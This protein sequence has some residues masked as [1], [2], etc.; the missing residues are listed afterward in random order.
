VTYVY[1]SLDR[2]V[3]ETDPPITDRVT[4][5]V[6]TEVTTYTY[7]PD[8]DVLTTSISDATGG[9][10]SRATTTTY[11]AYGDLASVTDPLGNVSKYTY[12]ALGDRIT[13]TNPAGVTTAY[14]YDAAGNLLTTS[15]EGYTGNPSNP[16]TAENLVQDSRSYDPAGNLASDTSVKGTTTHYTYYGNGQLASSYVVGSAGDEDVHTYTY[17]AAGNKVSETDPG[18]LVVNT[19]YNADSQVT[20]QTTDPAGVDHTTSAVYDADGNVVTQ[21]LTGGGV[22]QTETTTYNAMD[23]VLPQTTDKTG[24]NATTTYTRDHRGL[25]VSETD[26]AG[27]T[28]TYENDEAGR[29]VVT[30][31]PAVA[32][33]TGNGAAP[34]TA[35]PVTMIGYDTFGDE[36]ETSDADGNVTTYAYDQ[37]GQQVSVTDPSYTPPRAPRGSCPPTRLSKPR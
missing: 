37:D 10:A 3:K 12:D 32:S 30:T 19:V 23:Q 15:L 5:A 33:Q 16:I 25:V 31:S 24:G 18:G 2:V 17:D 6:H 28:A 20:S 29:A 34:M 8:D 14:T 9:D 21:T 26:P 35:N 1:D 36:T 7:D 27:N 22:T 11:D 13:L 4:G